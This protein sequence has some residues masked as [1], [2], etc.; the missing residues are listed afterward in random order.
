MFQ[1]ENA[2]CGS[3]ITARPFV[4]YIQTVDV[5]EAKADCPEK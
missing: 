1:T 5:L 3:K 2:L 4:R